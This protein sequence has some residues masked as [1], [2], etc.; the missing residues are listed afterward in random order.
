MNTAQKDPQ[1][2]LERYGGVFCKTL[3]V[4]D[5]SELAPKVPKIRV[6]VFQNA[7]EIISL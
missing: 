1:S 5:S 6:W 3:P 2:P 4:K 7:K